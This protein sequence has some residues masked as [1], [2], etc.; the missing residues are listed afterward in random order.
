[1]IRFLGKITSF[2]P[3]SISP[4]AGVSRKAISIWLEYGVV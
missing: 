2:P 3:A 1:M 4:A